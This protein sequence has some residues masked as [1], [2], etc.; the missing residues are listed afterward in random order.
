MRTRW[1]LAAA[2]AALLLAAACSEPGPAEKAGKA[3]DGAVERL[4]YGDEGTLEKAGR[5]LDEALE[6]LGEE[7]EREKPA[8]ES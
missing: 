4:R 1:M 5:K 8:D 2:P 3:I 7:R 6:E